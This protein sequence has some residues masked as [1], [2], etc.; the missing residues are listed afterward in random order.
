MECPRHS[1]RA[2][3][4]SLPTQDAASLYG[5]GPESPSDL[6][7][8]PSSF[9]SGRMF[10]GG[11]NFGLPRRPRGGRLRRFRPGPP[12]APFPSR[13]SCSAP[14]PLPSPPSWTRGP[15]RSTSSRHAASTASSASMPS[16]VAS[17]NRSFTTDSAR[18]SCE[19]NI[20]ACV[21]LG[22]SPHT[23][24][25]TRFPQARCRTTTTPRLPGCMKYGD[26]GS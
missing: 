20:F 23:F 12:R 7:C 3:H 22:I 4:F 6:G 5:S 19:I 25:T 14:P 8:P 1:P 10:V 2:S 24:G 21:R 18:S 9:E 11:S 15:R 16:S 13:S 17:R 26:F